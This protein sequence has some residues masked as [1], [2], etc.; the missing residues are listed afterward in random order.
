MAVVAVADEGF[1]SGLRPV[2]LA[3][4]VPRRNDYDIVRWRDGNLEVRRADFSKFTVGEGSLSFAPRVHLELNTEISGLGWA[5]PVLAGDRLVGLTISKGGNVCTV[6]PAPFVAG[7]FLV[8]N[9]LARF[10]EEAYR[11]ETQTPVA[12][13]LRLYQWIALAGVIVGAALTTLPSE[14]STGSWQPWWGALGVAA[15]L[16]AVV[17][18]ALGVDFPSSNRRFSRLV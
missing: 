13:G 14:A 3:A 17:G 7:M 6:M 16:G 10:V 2:D 12:Q 5:E 11:G 18:A 9:G 15:L 8:L 1:W 4:G